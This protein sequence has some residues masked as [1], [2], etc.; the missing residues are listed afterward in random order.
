MGKHQGEDC[1]DSFLKKKVSL[2]GFTGTL[3]GGREEAPLLQWPGPLDHLL[4]DLAS[5]RF[6]HH[7]PAGLPHSAWLSSSAADSTSASH[8][9]FSGY[10][11]FLLD[12]FAI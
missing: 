1:L 3:P 8:A 6:S 10:F 12:G 2:S 9:H 5:L 4:G 7:A 11:F